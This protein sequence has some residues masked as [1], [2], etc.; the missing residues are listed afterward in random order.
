MIQLLFGNEGSDLSSVSRVYMCLTATTLLLGLPVIAACLAAIAVFILQGSTGRTSKSLDRWLIMS[1]TS[2]AASL[3]SWILVLLSSRQG[4]G[5]GS[6]Q[7]WFFGMALQKGWA[8]GLGYLLYVDFAYQYGTGGG[9]RRGGKR[10]SLEATLLEIKVRV[11]Q[12]RDLVAK[13]TNI[14]GRSTTSDP[15]VIVHMGPNQ[16]GRTSIVPKDLD[17]V[18]PPNQYFRLNVL[19]RSIEVYKQIEFNIY[20]N[21]KLSADDPMGT[22]FVTIPGM[23]NLKVVN[24]Y[25]V[26]NGEG[27]DHCR[28]ATGELLVEVQVLSKP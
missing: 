24:W 20:D 16:M 7:T 18:W 5:S 6:F 10:H 23:R 1:S 3:G 14:F 11:L 13:D 15:Y 21:D 28:N 27:Q 22:V 25:R 19:A 26:E 17:P 2:T 12:G 4:S 9:G 8:L